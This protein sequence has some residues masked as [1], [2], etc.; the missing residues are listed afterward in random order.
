MNELLK[1]LRRSSLSRTVERHGEAIEHILNAAD[2]H[3]RTLESLIRGV[4]EN[5]ARTQKQIATMQGEI[6]KL[7]GI[8]GA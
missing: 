5:A 2:S 6:N 7:K 3:N 1:R 8:H 4:A